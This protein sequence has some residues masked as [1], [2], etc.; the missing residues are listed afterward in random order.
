MKQLKQLILIPIITL[1]MMSFSQCDRSKFDKNSPIEISDSHYQSWVGGKP[2]SSGTLV[3]IIA[4]VSN[5][6]MVFDSIYFHKKATKLETQIKEE[7][8]TLIANFIERSYQD[9]DIVM[10][11]DPK[12]EYGNKP[13]VLI[14]KIPFDLKN[15]EA[16]ISYFIKEKKRYYKLTNIRKEK[17]IYYQ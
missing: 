11:S 4:K 1:V 2:G 12:E 6:H 8:L 5:K 10:S 14:K 3:T 13:P 15:N 9:Q 16:I 7:K 17:P